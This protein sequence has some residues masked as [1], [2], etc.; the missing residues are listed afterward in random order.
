MA[1]PLFLTNINSGYPSHNNVIPSDGQKMNRCG[2]NFDLNGC[3]ERF[4]HGNACQFAEPCTS[5]ISGKLRQIETTLELEQDPHPALW[6]KINPYGQLLAF[7]F[8]LSA[9]VLHLLLLDMQKLCGGDFS[10][11]GPTQS[12]FQIGD[13]DTRDLVVE[14][15]ALFGNK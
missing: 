11:G 10:S 2:L 1:S 9:E 4:N 7:N 14:V 6:S 15:D 3:F 8:V 5:L 12:C 13:F